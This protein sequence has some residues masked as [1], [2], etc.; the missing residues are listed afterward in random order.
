VQ[1]QYAIN[2]ELERFVLRRPHGPDL[3]LL[4]SWIL[5]KWQQVIKLDKVQLAGIGW[6]PHWY[7]WCPRGCL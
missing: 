7:I 5:R 6:K 4:K 1:I 2:R 3:T